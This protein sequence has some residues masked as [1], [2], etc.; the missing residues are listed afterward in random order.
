MLLEWESSRKYKP[1]AKE[2]MDV[3]PEDHYRIKESAGTGKC[4][5]VSADE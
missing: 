4:G 5:G 1:D 2:K 3:D